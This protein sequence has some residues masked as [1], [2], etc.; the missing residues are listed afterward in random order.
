MVGFSSG[1][2]SEM[3]S[4]V[5]IVTVYTILFQF[6]CKSVLRSFLQF[7]ARSEGYNSKE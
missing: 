1:T 7:G 4:V 6:Y 5:Y 2:I 3:F